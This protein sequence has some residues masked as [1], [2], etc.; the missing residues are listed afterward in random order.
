MR[1]TRAQGLTL[2]EL[3]VAMAIM[4]IIFMLI[5]QWQVSTL[6][7]STRSNAMSRSLGDLN[8]L[9]GYLGD[10]VRAAVR[11]RVATSGLSVNAGAGSACSAD[12][13]CLAVVLPEY[14]PSGV[15]SRYNLY[16]Y[17]MMPRSAVTH[18]DDKVEDPWAEGQVQVLKEYRSED[19]GSA[20]THCVLGVGETFDT[21]AAPACATMRSLG[22]ATAFSGLGSYL[23]AD[24]L[25]PASSLGAGQVPFAYD[26]ATRV[27]T[28]AFQH[29]QQVRGQTTALPAAEPYTLQVQA[30]NVP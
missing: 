23:V 21:A 1:T 19:S 13:P 7:I 16:V 28:L 26:S 4:G 12:R 17:R 14:S 9:S 3:L 22:S 6:N 11:V 15:V 29:R 8:D 18:P 25:T 30:R 5:T 10:R 2:V 20:P 27:I 24:Y